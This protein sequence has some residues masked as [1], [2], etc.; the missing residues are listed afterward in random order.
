MLAWL[1]FS[2]YSIHCMQRLLN[3]VEQ[4]FLSNHQCKLQLL[5]GLPR[6]FKSALDQIVLHNHYSLSQWS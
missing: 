3:E 5:T 1:K 2:S 6:C 4:G